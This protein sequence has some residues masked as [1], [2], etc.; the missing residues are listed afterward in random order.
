[1][2]LQGRSAAVTFLRRHILRSGS[3]HNE[4]IHRPFGLKGPDPYANS[5]VCNSCTDCFRTGAD[6]ALRLL[7]QTEAA[8]PFSLS[9]MRQRKA[10][11]K[12][13]SFSVQAL[14][15]GGGYSVTLRLPE[16]EGNRRSLEIQS[17]LAIMKN[18]PALSMYF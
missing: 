4:R 7:R 18:R 13:E 2:T 9:H 11:P 1:M 3:I 8:F 5:A 17:S 14:L 6:A 12:R 16:K 15:R 10:F